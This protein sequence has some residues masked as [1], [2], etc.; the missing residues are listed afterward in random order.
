MVT[1]KFGEIIPGLVGHLSKASTLRGSFERPVP[2]STI[3]PKSF[4]LAAVAAT[5]RRNF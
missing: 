3:F 4:V 5:G 2:S 1:T